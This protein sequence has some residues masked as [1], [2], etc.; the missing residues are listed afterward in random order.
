MEKRK[1]I[2]VM[3]GGTGTFVVLSGLKHFPV[4]LTAVVTMADTGGS[5]RLERDRYG[6]LPNSDVRKALIGLSEINGKR[7]GLLREL[8]SYRFDRGEM[9]GMTFGNLLLVVLS[10]VL[11]SQEEAIARAGE[12]LRIKGKVLPVT[13]DKIDL[14]ARYEDGS[15]V[16]GEHLIDEPEHDGK[17]KIVELAA[18][19]KG[20][21]F[22]SAKT[23]LE[24]AEMI[25]FGPGDLY[26]STLAPVVV[27]DVG[28][29]I[30]D[31][32]AKLVYVVN[33]MTKYGQTYG[34]KASD[35][36]EEMEKYVGRKMEGVVINS[37]RLPA[38]ALIKYEAEQAVPVED[39]L[40]ADPRVMRADVLQPAE[41]EPESGDP[42]KR[43]LLR[44]DPEKLAK[45]VV[46]LL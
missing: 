7:G 6:L 9:A 10:R 40:G 4:E 23:A 16:M 35:H 46:N 28:K 20:R 33:L 15:M 26:T 21:I 37:S 44:H 1:K 5:A 31:S 12:I 41:V 42:L 39:D 8:L 19:P 11:G 3:G 24:A 38:E 13:M 22:E 36:L 25:V 32:K 43:S 2:V 27:D 34:F 17:L 30:A 45:V 14:V 18:R 29:L